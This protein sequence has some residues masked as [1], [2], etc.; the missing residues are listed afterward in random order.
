MSTF[1]FILIAIAIVIINC[2]SSFIL[3]GPQDQIDIELSEFNI[4]TINAANEL[5]M[6]YAQGY[7]SAKFRLWQME[8]QKRTVSGTLSEIFGEST[9]ESDIYFRTMRFR[10]LVKNDWDSPHTYAE[11]DKKIIQS[12]VNGINDFTRTQNIS[13]VAPEFDFY[14]VP[15]QNFTYMDVLLVGKYLSAG[16]S[17][18]AETEFQR[19]NFLF[20]GLSRTKLDELF[21]SD[22][23]F[24]PVYPSSNYTVDCNVFDFANEFNGFNGFDQSLNIPPGSKSN[25]PP[26][27]IS[28]RKKGNFAS[29][30]WVFSKGLTKKSV[31]VANDPHLDY[32]VPGQFFIISLNSPTFS[33]KGIMIPGL[34]GIAIGRNKKLAW[35]FTITG[36]D[37]QDLFIMQNNKDDT[38]YFHQN[39]WINYQTHQEKIPVRGSKKFNLQYKYSVYGPVYATDDTDHT[40]CLKW[41]ALDKLDTTVSGLINLA[42]FED[43][44]SFFLNALN[45]DTLN[46]NMVYG[47]VSN[48]IAMISVGNIVHRQRGLDGDLPQLGNGQF[49]WLGYY[50]RSQNQMSL[51][52]NQGYLASANNRL[53][54]HPKIGPDFDFDIGL[55]AER[56]AC[57]IHDHIDK[58]KQIDLDFNKFL[59]TDVKTYLFDYMKPLLLKLKLL[60]QK[61]IDWKNKLMNWDGVASVQSVEVT[62]FRAWYLCLAN[63]TLKEPIAEHWKRPDFIHLIFMQDQSNK[64]CQKSPKSD[65]MDCV[66]YASECFSHAIDL[67]VNKIPS[68][69][70]IHLAKFPHLGEHTENEKWDLSQSVGGDPYTLFDADS[71]G[72]GS[73]QFLATGGPVARIIADLST[74]KLLVMIPSGQSGNPNDAS[75]SDLMEKWANGKYISI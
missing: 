18:N 50:P 63:I 14:R 59:Q 71:D 16:L 37:T 41:T 36:T 66:I 55:R 69:G 27:F 13:K 32:Q 3:N 7:I 54:I 53:G 52:P 60:S 34:P 44:S 29:N 12:Y 26:K 19:R 39:K 23:R 47:D 43:L 24:P 45:I 56:I 48:N 58:G 9:L 15:I 61:E 40:L 6:F 5:D 70:E 8:Y 20:R 33:G 21:H 1:K 4:P 17:G 46:L 10:H 28:V 75:Y 22:H 57:A 74:D 72:M 49:D 67:F 73:E 42:R 2:G 68:W 62:L 38:A 64:W 65:S 51:N 30:N 35:G 31:I 11:S 25:S